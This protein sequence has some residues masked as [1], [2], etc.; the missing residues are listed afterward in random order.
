M[1]LTID[2]TL[3][4]KPLVGEAQATPYELTPL[5]RSIVQN[6]TK[7]VERAALTF[8]GCMDSDDGQNYNQSGEVTQSY[9]TG[10]VKLQRTFT[11]ECLDYQN[12]TEYYC[13]G[14]SFRRIAHECGRCVG[15]ACAKYLE[16]V[17]G[18]PPNENR[19]LDIIAYIDTDTSDW[20]RTRDPDTGYSITTE[21]WFNISATE[22]DVRR[23]LDLAAQLFYEKTGVSLI[24]RDVRL[25]SF[26]WMASPSDASGPWVKEI[27]ETEAEPPEILIVFSPRNGAWINGGYMVFPEPAEEDS[28]YCNEFEIAHPDIGQRGA[29][30]MIIDWDIRYAT[31]GYDRD[32][33]PGRTRISETPILRNSSRGYYECRDNSSEICVLRTDGL[34]Y[35][36]GSTL[37][38]LSSDRDFLIASTVIHEI[39]HLLD[40]EQY[41][42]YGSVTCADVPTSDEIGIQAFRRAA[43]E[44]FGMCP[45][46][47]PLIIDHFKGCPI[48]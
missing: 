23:V 10:M 15:G 5:R 13:K 19:A 37:S 7:N 31:C 38:D 25:K 11:D 34:Y 35:Q 12:L 28:L 41:G 40:T 14:N 4:E 26:D 45:K 18:A 27:L 22:P 39:A 46:T 17:P 32:T 43:Q 33:P 9:K 20:F 47:F 8:T 29:G 36:C 48:S 24:V 1:A 2:A 44:S 42:H 30:A 6:V 21:W 16:Y 3:S